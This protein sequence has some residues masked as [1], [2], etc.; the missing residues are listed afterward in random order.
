MAGEII[1]GLH[2]HEHEHEHEE[3]LRLQAADLNVG[4]GIL[5]QS[6]LF[7]TGFSI[8]NEYSIE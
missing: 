4:V 7:V 5:T 8:F 3:I 1:A 6:L 2:E